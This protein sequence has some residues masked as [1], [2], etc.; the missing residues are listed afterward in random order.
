MDLIALIADNAGW[1]WLIFGLVLL[2]VELVVPGVF[3][4]WLGG[5]ALLTGLTAYQCADRPPAGSRNG[6]GR[7]DQ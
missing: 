7:S 6:T 5:A 4:V 3:M 1:A 2:G